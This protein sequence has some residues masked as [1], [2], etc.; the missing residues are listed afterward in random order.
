MRGV[1]TIVNMMHYSLSSDFASVRLN[2]YDVIRS[3]DLA[4]G[5]RNLW[6]AGTGNYRVFARGVPGG[7]VASSIVGSAGALCHTDWYDQLP[8][9]L[10]N[11]RL[12]LVRCNHRVADEKVLLGALTRRSPQTRSTAD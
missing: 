4:A 5:S 1:H 2:Y 3:S 12:R 6:S 11:Y 8:D 7:Y 10:V 9:S